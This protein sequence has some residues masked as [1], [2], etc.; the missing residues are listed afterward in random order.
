M[1]GSDREYMQTDFMPGKPLPHCGTLCISIDIE[2]AWGIWDKITPAAQRMIEGS[3]RPVIRRLIQLFDRHNVSATWAIVGRLIGRPS[4]ASDRIG[5]AWHAPEILDWLRNAEVDHDIGSHGFEHVYFCEVDAQ[6]ASD[7]I[8]AARETHQIL[9]LPFKSFVFPRNQVNHLSVL[10]CSGISIYRSKDMGIVGVVERRFP[11]LRQ[12]ANF[13]DKLLPMTPP[14]VFPKANPSGM[15][16]LESSTL[17]MSRNGARRIIR[18]NVTLMRHR[19]GLK[20]AVREG[21]VFHLWFHPSNFY[22]QSELQFNILDY[23]LQKAVS[24]REK[25]LLEIRTMTDFA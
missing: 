22:Y 18:P 2:M 21:G 7:D 15:T 6:L 13:I 10:A 4:I 5:P 17:L 25:G 19:A 3:D 8:N 23:T 16:E 24:L 20:K 9:G 11:R 14:V 1:I 12:A